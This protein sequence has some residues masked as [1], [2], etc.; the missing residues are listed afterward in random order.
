[1]DRRRWRSWAAVL[2]L[3]ALG[4]ARAANA[5]A[6]TLDL[7]ELED[8]YVATISGTC[9]ELVIGSRVVPTCG[10]ELLNVDFA[11][12]R[13]AFVFA[14]RVDDRIVVTI[15]SGGSSRQ[16][17]GRTYELAIDRMT[18]AIL[19]AAEGAVVAPA[20][21]ACTMRGDPTEEPTRFEC[22]VRSAGRET[23]ARFRSSGDPAATES[24]PLGA[25]PTASS[26]FGRAVF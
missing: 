22:R 26:A 8:G 5:G 23:I 4:D 6:A 21:G 24:A 10:D 20:E 3:A 14:G 13:V 1:M 16:P 17:N 25:G 7:E 18:T 15:L 19:G 2:V 9:E 12:G 11:N